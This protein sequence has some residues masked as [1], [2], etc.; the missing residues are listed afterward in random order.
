MVTS[1]IQK[2]IDENPYLIT[3]IYL[4]SRDQVYENMGYRN[5]Y[6]MTSCLSPTP[7]TKLFRQLRVMKSSDI[8]RISSI[9]GL[10]LV[11]V[12]FFSFG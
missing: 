11:F 5:T 8:I 7:P 3:V 9:K 4:T 6:Y 2:S 12:A 1:A 10:L